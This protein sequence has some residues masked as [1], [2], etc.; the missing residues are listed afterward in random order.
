MADWMTHYHQ[1]EA[2]ALGLHPKVKLDDF[3]HAIIISPRYRYLFVNVPKVACTTIR[4]LLLDAEHGEVRPYAEREELHYNEFLPF[5]NIQQVGNVKTFVTRPD[6]FKFCFVRNPYTRLLSGYLDKIVRKKDQRNP[7]LRQLGLFHQ[8]EVELSFAQFV[9]AVV[10]LPVMHQDQHWRVQYY[11][12]C[13][14]G[15]KYDFIGRFE[16]L[17]QDLRAVAQQIG[18]GAFIQEDTFGNTATKAVG[19]HHATGAAEQLSSYYTP[20]LQEMVYQK[21]REDFD[22]FGYD[23]ALPTI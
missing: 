12:T 13:Q 15:I 2:Q 8:P 20:A 9:Q 17:E 19:Q 6:I 1:F 4:K 10:D 5:L 18:I 11:Q 7:I 3:R 22:C 16:S 14:A 21:Y 23:K